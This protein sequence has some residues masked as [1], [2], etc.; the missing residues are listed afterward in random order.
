MD[1]EPVTPHSTLYREHGRYALVAG[2]IAIWLLMTVLSVVALVYMTS[3]QEQLRDIVS[4]HNTKKD[5]V[6]QMHASA[7][8]RVFSL[9]HMLLV[10]DPFER[11]AE[12]I[13]MY[14]HGVTFS[15]ARD[16]FMQLPLASLEQ[17][18]M[19]RHALLANRAGPTQRDAMTLILEDEMEKGRHLLLGEVIPI[20]QQA[21]TL[22]K[23]LE[24]YQDA[25]IKQALQQGEEAFEDARILLVVLGGIAVL[26]LL[27]IAMKVFGVLRTSAQALN[28]EKDRLRITLHSIG[29][30]VIAT[31]STGI[32][33][34]INPVAEQFT[35]WNGEA[36][37]GVN[38]FD[39]FNII[40]A[41]NGK[42]VAKS[43]DDLIDEA[44]NNDIHHHS[45]LRRR[46]DSTLAVD[47]TTS[48][49]RHTDGNIGGYVTI[50][51]DE[52]SLRE[53]ANHLSH[54]ASHDPL[55]N[56]ANRRVFEHH[57]ELLLREDE[58]SRTEHVLCYLDLD[59][60]KI[61]NDTCGH[62]A[63]DELLKQ[64]VALFRQRVRSN[65]LL[66]R[67]GGDE[68]GLLLENCPVQRAMGIADEIRES[69]HRYRFIWK[70][71]SFHIGVSIGM[72]VIDNRWNNLPELLAAADAACYA[73]KDGGRNR[74]HLY[75][76]GDT[77]TTNIDE[78]SWPERI[79]YAL[80]HNRLIHYSQ[81][82]VALR[83]SVPGS[84]YIYLQLRI[85]EQGRQRLPFAPLLPQAER[86]GLAPQ[87]D[88]WA[89]ENALILAVL[90]EESSA[91][92][93][94]ALSSA[95]LQDEHFAADIAALAQQ[96]S[97]SPA[98]ICLELPENYLLANIQNASTATLRL[99][100]MGFRIA[101]EGTGQS[102]GTHDT[103]RSLPF[104]Y[105]RI[106]GD[107]I[108]EAMDDPILHI[109]LEANVRMA[110]SIG[111]YVVAMDIQSRQVIEQLDD[112]GVDYLSG[113]GIAKPQPAIALLITDLPAETSKL[114]R[115]RVR[116]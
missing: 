46:D 22:L 8:E 32:I 99:T 27:F 80:E 6:K 50:F 74:I 65:D 11:D 81:Q 56:L 38:I 96:R 116:S 92:Y 98:Q 21:M 97:I 7:R 79:R 17:D 16:R 39:V 112:I 68:F 36:A 67:I 43:I 71:Q 114:K 12:T 9:Q 10:D 70:G 85:K 54:Q 53:M 34:Y 95:S 2:Y 89:V 28:D 84:S 41:A 73:A 57:L 3:I 103:L 44:R 104:D 94:I 19:S 88:R 110:H 83:S 42:P 64:I 69:V 86:H 115:K 52:S 113:H 109:Q 62:A 37:R 4:I 24:E 47:Y 107:F 108:H 60:F 63:G 61:V 26:M 91:I 90:R 20:Q 87:I 105:L 48:A 82:P 76:S 55:T 23:E 35:G 101:L 93:S 33:E 49:I 45:L 51:R 40:N 18:I 30:G 5:L 66:A 13:K 111:M 1:S 77:G 14:Q 58:T 31:D 59:R 78:E 102:I 75:I 29:D 72:V 100:E 25:S 15:Q 106:H